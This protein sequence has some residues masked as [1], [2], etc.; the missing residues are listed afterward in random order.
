MRSK[1][2]LI[3]EGEKEEP[4]ILGSNSH[5][6]LSLIGSNYDIVTF[7]NPIYELYDAYK[8]GDYD[9]IV[10][11][12]RVEKGLEI[13]K[14]ILSKNAF[15]SIYLVFD[16]EPHYHKYKDSKIKDILNVFNNETELGKLYINY[17]M[18]ESFYYLKNIPDLEYL[19]R[20]IS[21]NNFN[22]KDY[23]KLVNNET[24]LKKNK[25]SNKQLCY[26]IWINYNKVRKI[27]NSKEINH[28]LILDEQLKLKKST[29]EL[30]ILSTLPLLI[31]DYNYDKKI[32]IIKEKI[33]N[34]EV[35]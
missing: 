27:I 22:G 3:V 6:L 2:L 12:L 11:Y 35:L 20:K 33:K 25:L 26:I 24:I 30:Y 8:K 10:S 14:N 29:N 21:L 23:K 28:E 5:G 4:R 1:I 16:F 31:L 7:S 34:I 32:K 17:P 18:V 15:S 13:D 9:D 19:G